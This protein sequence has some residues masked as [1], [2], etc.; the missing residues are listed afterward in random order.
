MRKDKTQLQVMLT[1]TAIRTTSGEIEGYLGVAMD[2]SEQLAS[3]A[4]VEAVTEQLLQAASV[5]NL[6]I[7]NWTLADNN[8]QWNEQMYRLYQQD[9]KLNETAPLNYHHWLE[10]VH[11][12]DSALA[13]NS[14]QAALKGEANYDLVFRLSLPDGTLRYIKAQARVSRNKS[15]APVAMT[16][17]NVDITELYLHEEQLRLARDLAQQANLAKSQF[18]ANMSHE[19]RTPMNAVLGMLQL[20]RTTKLNERQQEYSRNAIGAA[21]SLLGLLND[22]LDF[23]KIEAGKLQLDPHEFSVEQLLHEVAIVISSLAAAK[24][25]VELIFDV[26]REIPEYLIGDKLRLQ[27]IL[28]NLTTNALKFT[29]QG[30]VKLSMRMLAQSQNTVTLEVRV[31]DTGIGIALEHQQKIFDGFTQAETSTTRRFG[32][33]GLGLVIC[34]RLLALMY[35]QL[36]LTSAPGVGSEFCFALELP[37]GKSQNNFKTQHYYQHVLLIEHKARSSALIAEH[38]TAWSAIITKAASAEDAVCLFNAQS[39]NNVDLVVIDWHASAKDD[40]TALPALQ[41]LFSNKLPAVVFVV[42]LQDKESMWKHCSEVGITPAGIIMKPIIPWHWQHLFAKLNN[43][44]AV[45]LPPTIEAA[46]LDGVH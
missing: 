42:T 46:G 18:L 37:L 13:E 24:P 9:P 38:L 2:I 6:G 14:L 45:A 4:Q 34:Q 17:I 25:Q 12:E 3:Q 7:W 11:P 19:I 1:A 40:Q 23:S 31:Q 8:L 36:T 28:I 16:G 30:L 32:G 26:H 22:I 39:V 41:K 15:G 44:P 10:R 21:Q 5:A 29:E 20:L 33:T 27:Q 35:G 43:E